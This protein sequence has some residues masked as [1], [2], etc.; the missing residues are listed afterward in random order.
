MIQHRESTPEVWHATDAIIRVDQ[1]DIKRLAARAEQ[2]PR[3]R[4]RLCMH[5][6]SSAP[7]HE[8]LIVHAKG[9]Y[10]RPHKHLNKSESFHIVEG[11]V[12]VVLLTE[13]AEITEVIRMGDYRSGRPY[14]YRLN[15]PL[16]HTLFIRSPQVLFHEVTNGPFHRADTLF[17][18]GTP[19]IDNEPEAHRY[20]QFLEASIDEFCNT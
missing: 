19:E 13:A 6:D 2:L 15:Q 3:G 11:E 4:A 12:D 9:C 18:P 8:M 16:Y 1:E 7:L 14:Y 10:V 17:L 20:M 5:E